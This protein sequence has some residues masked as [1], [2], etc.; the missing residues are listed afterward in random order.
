LYSSLLE[1]K[2]IEKNVGLN[3]VLKQQR[4]I[5]NHNLNS[6]PERRKGEVEDKEKKR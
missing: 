3:K 6:F 4:K 2:Y 5:P 1:I